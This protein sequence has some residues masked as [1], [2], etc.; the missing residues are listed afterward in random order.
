MRNEQVMQI[1]LDYHA[2]TTV[3]SGAGLAVDIARS[4]D[5]NL[6]ALIE[7][8]ADSV[9]D[10]ELD[11]DPTDKKTKRA[12]RPAGLRTLRQTKLLKLSTGSAGAGGNGS[13]TN[14]TVAST[15]MS[16]EAP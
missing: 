14:E 9:S 10:D 3:Q 4:M 1:L 16:A 8:Y 11:L 6:A 13:I 12:S 5:A 2:D 7:S 15:G